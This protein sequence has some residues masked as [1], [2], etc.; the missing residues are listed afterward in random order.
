ML[1][2]FTIVFYI[3]GTYSC[4]SRYYRA[5]SNLSVLRWSI[6]V[7]IAM[8]IG[9]DCHYEPLLAQL[10]P[11]TPIEPLLPIINTELVSGLPR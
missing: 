1:L 11:N 10:L 4:I 5:T 8:L 2:G 3:P 7:E 6:K 9:E